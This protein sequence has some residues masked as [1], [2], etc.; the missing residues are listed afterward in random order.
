MPP[1]TPTHT[2]TTFHVLRGEDHRIY[3]RRV[4]VIFFTTPRTENVVG[5][6][7]FRNRYV[8][9]FTPDAVKP[10][11]N[12]NIQKSQFAWMVKDQALAKAFFCTVISKNNGIENMLL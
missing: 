4:C 12:N 2:D 8:V 1:I 5:E 10:L 9:M 3:P 7:A 11:T 6:E